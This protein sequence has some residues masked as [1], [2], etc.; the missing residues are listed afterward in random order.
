MIQP[1]GTN[2][3]GNAT[4]L[5]NHVAIVL[6][7]SGSM[8]SMRREA[9]DAFNQQANDIQDKA[10]DQTTTVSLVKFSTTVPNPIYWA[11]PVERLRPIGPDDYAPDGM[12]AMLDAVGLTIDRL[13]K[14]PD[15]NDEDTSF[16]VLIISDGCENNSK[17]YSYQDIAERIQELDKTDRWTFTYLGANQDLARVAAQMNIPA[18]NV[19][20]FAADAS[21]M[22]D[23]A[24]QM[25]VSSARFFEG[26]RTGKKSSKDFYTPAPDDAPPRPEG[27]GQSWDK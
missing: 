26:R 10:K 22:A 14:L 2:G 5:A 3:S 13:K 6:D 17:R 23:G 8:N 18:A 21:G 20:P 12:T 27:D 19:S 11:E 16:L 1:N 7:E 25:R 15:A 24:L 9:I 4:V